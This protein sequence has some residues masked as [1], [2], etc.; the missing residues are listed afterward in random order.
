MTYEIT[1]IHV[2]L[3]DN[4]AQAVA[5]WEECYGQKI[6]QTAAFIAENR[7]HS[8]VVLLAGPSGSGK[9]TTAARICQRLETMG[10]RTHLLSM[11]N[12]FLT[13]SDPAFPRLPNGKP[14]LEAPGCLDLP[15]LEEHFSKLE[16]GGDIQ[17]P[18]Y[19]FP[20]HSRLKNKSIPLDARSGD[21][22]VFEGIHGLNPQFTQKH[23]HACRIYVSPEDEF[24]WNGEL[25]CKPVQLR[26]ARRLVRDYLFRGATIDYSLDLW[27]NVIVSEG[28]Y[29]TP[30]RGSAHC[31]ISTTLPYELGI[32]RR[33][34][35][36]L[37]ER[38]PKEASCRAEALALREIL[39]RMTPLDTLLVPKDSI[40]REFI[41]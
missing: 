36:P 20:S 35:L 6:E 41:G 30:Y 31:T 11:D 17:V 34:A 4:P 15:L 13:R 26:L 12:Y 22:F 3:Q 28:K 2:Q 23:P 40:L 8:P 9:T 24:T 29:I 18:V 38:L 7:K 21:V 14:D 32:L 39:F 27:P 5:L 16:T 33:L 25:F 19:D 10:I 37:L 1:R